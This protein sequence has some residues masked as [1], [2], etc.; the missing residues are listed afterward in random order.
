MVSQRL[1]QQRLVGTT[2]YGEKS[3][4]LLIVFNKN[5]VIGLAPRGF[6]QLAGQSWTAGVFS[7][8]L[9]PSSRAV[10][11]PNFSSEEPVVFKPMV[12][13]DTPVGSGALGLQPISSESPNGSIEA[14]GS[15]NQSP[16]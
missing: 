12:S 5:Y 6:S 16:I 2:N 13:N 10:V 15:P 14:R 9:L 7:E 1:D 4:E 11:E 8:A 3:R